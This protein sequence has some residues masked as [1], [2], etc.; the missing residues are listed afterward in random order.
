MPFVN[1]YEQR[2]KRA[3]ALKAEQEAD[4]LFQGAA[5]GSANFQKMIEAKKTTEPKKSQRQ[6]ALDDLRKGLADE[7]SATGF[8][9]AK[10][11]LDK[12]TARVN[13]EYDALEQQQPQSTGISRLASFF[14]PT[15]PSQ[16][17]MQQEIASNANQALPSP[18][19]TEQP[20][21]QDIVP[22]PAIP[23]VSVSKWGEK[24][25]PDFDAE[26]FATKLGLTIQAKE[27]SQRRLKEEERIA[28]P[29]LTVDKEFAKQYNDW[30]SKDSADMDLNLT[31]LRD[32]K[33]KIEAAKKA[34]QILDSS[35]RVIGILPDWFKPSLSLEI[36]D[37]VHAAAVG[38]L[39]A[40][41]GANPSESEGRN[42]MKFSYDE[43]LS[44]EVNLKKIDDTIK[45]LEQKKSIKNQQVSYFG[46]YGTLKGFKAA[47]GV[48]AKT[49]GSRMIIRGVEHIKTEG[50]WIPVPGVQPAPQQG[51]QP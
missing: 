1:E 45:N 14:Q 41:F 32:A 23:S 35:G 7:A 33:A 18:M 16:Q 22:Q 39:K 25:K 30:V 26:E 21:A 27:G 46:K 13:A 17:P 12:E 42:F 9:V 8:Y 2:F 34:N 5:E 49:I 28:A 6:Q 4:P 36:R 29:Q 3:Q 10:D 20:V 44:P 19:E 37:N 43:K 31:R 47:S 38:G 50:G 40:A 51:V 11:Y 15:T 48:A 24:K